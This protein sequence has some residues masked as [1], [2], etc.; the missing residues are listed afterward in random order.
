MRLSKFTAAAL[1][2]LLAAGCGS[3]PAPE[4]SQ[5]TT[6]ATPTESANPTAAYN[7]LNQALSVSIL[8]AGETGVMEYYSDG[9][10]AFF[11]AVYDPNSE[12]DYHG[13]G[14]LADGSDP[15]LL[16]DLSMYVLWRAQD[17][18]AASTATD[19]VAAGDRS[20]VLTIDTSKPELQ[21]FP[22]E[23]RITLSADGLVASVYYPESESPDSV[24]VTYEVTAVGTDILQRANDWLAQ[25]G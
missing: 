24:R 4:P 21:Y 14:E 10:A 2:L 25:Q 15:E 9:D 18:L 11:T 5:S 20:F 3:D 17:A 23:M 16:L 12:L 22:A 1:I 19:V 13:A 8:Q 7:A 6:S